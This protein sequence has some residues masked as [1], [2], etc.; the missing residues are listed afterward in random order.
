MNPALSTPVIG[1]NVDQVDASDAPSQVL[2]TRITGAD[3][4]VFQYVK[5]AAALITTNY[6]PNAVAID[7]DSNASLMTST[8]A[9][10][11]YQLGFAPLGDNITIAINQ[12][13]WARIAGTGFNARVSASASADRYLRTTATAGRLGTA[14]NASQVVFAGVVILTAASASN[15]SGGTV[16][17]V[18]AAN[19]ARAIRSGNNFVE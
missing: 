14:S 16:R 9:L 17:E 1:A 10:A 5:A 13:F 4:T 8:L 3:G 12:Y 7:E 11:N 15:G 2:G 19:P 18:F 6:S